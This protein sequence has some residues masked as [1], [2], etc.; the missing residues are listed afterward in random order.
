MSQSR[1]KKICPI[2]CLILLIFCNPSK[3]DGQNQKRFSFDLLVSTIRHLT[4]SKSSILG[5]YRIRPGVGMSLLTKGDRLHRISIREFWVK[6]GTE[7]YIDNVSA[8]KTN[9]DTSIR[10][11]FQLS[12]NQV[13]FHVFASL[14]SSFSKRVIEPE[15]ASYF[16][17]TWNLYHIFPEFEIF[18][19][20]DINV[21]RVSLSIPIKIVEIE[22][23]R[24]YAAN[25]SIP[26]NQQIQ[27]R[28]TNFE[29]FPSIFEFRL[30]ISI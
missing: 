29:F 11:E 8:Q 19:S 27:W 28:K 22:K 7:L 20:F 23:I 17:R 3:V 26:K 14:L 6:E 21:S 4:D 15:R 18:Y 9:L 12:K 10:Y 24:Y 1:V 13:G 30:G 2:L 5:D 25:P 16:D